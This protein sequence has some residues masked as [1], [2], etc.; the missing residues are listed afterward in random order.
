MRLRH[1][2]SSPDSPAL[3]RREDNEGSDPH[4]QS[5][6]KTSFGDGSLIASAA[7][8][9]GTTREVTCSGWKW[10]WAQ[11]SSTAGRWPRASTRPVMKV[12][13]FEYIRTSGNGVVGVK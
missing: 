1:S 6:V 13:P 5:L 9:K 3:K 4:V 11:A 8:E 10:P 2:E 12:M 7:C